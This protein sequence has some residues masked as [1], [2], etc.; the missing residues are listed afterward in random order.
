M[1]ITKDEFK[2]LMSYYAQTTSFS[3][4]ETDLDSIVEYLYE[5]V[6]MKFK[7]KLTEALW[8]KEVPA[9]NPTPAPLIPTT[10]T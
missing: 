1:E 4:T 10:L 8:E 7:S 5:N 9:V 3:I 2:G 6:N